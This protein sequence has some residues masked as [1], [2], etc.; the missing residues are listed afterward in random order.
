MI[1]TLK[2]G[3]VFIILVGPMTLKDERKPSFCSFIDSAFNMA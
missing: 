3:E 2:L 1:I